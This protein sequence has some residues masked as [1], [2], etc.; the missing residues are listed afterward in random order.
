MSDLHIGNQ[1]IFSLGP[2]L[3]RVAFHAFPASTFGSR[4]STVAGA[5]S[6]PITYQDS[7]LK[8]TLSMH[9]LS[10]LLQIPAFAF[11]SSENNSFGFRSPVL[12][13]P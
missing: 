13:H 2:P 3:Y 8:P 4:T 12:A 5:E 10:T 6:N 1:V 7:K 11:S 9:V